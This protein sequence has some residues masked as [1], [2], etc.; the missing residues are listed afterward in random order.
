[1]P[2]LPE[3]ETVKRGLEKEIVNKVIA[4]LQVNL[5][6]LLK[7]INVNQF[8]ELMTGKM[9]KAVQRRGKY[10]LCLLDS[11]DTLVFH[12]GMSGLLLYQ[13]KEETV[14]P[15]I[16]QKHNHL[17]FAFEDGTKMIYNDV[18]QFGKI[19]LIRGDEKLPELESLG[20]EPLGE[21]FTFAKFK[22]VIQN[23]K[24]NIKSLLMNQKNIAGIGNIY[25]NETLFYAG[26][27]PL[28][29]GDSL[30]TQELKKL[31]FAIKDTLHK[32]IILGGTTMADESYRNLWGNPGN[33]APE[34]LVYGKKNGYCPNCGCPLSIIRIENRST[35]L[36]PDCQR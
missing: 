1:M 24:G 33:F 26:I 35:F 32:A 15:K 11:S 2:E 7:N 3:V 9:I 17:F 14:I 6:R 31:Y 4:A 16:K 12:L 36:C 13:K 18:R 28:R 5:P 27:H 10:I 20:W 23:K 29:K 30:S 19:W 25:A 22:E 21:D 8:Q 34:I